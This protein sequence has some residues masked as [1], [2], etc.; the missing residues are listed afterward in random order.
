[1]AVNL[2]EIAEIHMLMYE[3]ESLGVT[4]DVTECWNRF[5]VKIKTELKQFLKDALRR[6][7]S[8]FITEV[9]RIG[10]EFI[11]DFPKLERKVYAA[12][13]A[14]KSQFVQELDRL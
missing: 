10:A 3:A 9:N 1:M 7:Q 13:E 14:M 5:E 8:F 6:L 2:R 11:R 12:V 4:E